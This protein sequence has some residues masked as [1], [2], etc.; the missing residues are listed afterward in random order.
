[1]E[2]L[3]QKTL[4]WKLYFIKILQFSKISEVSTNLKDNIQISET[5]R[6]T[7]DM[8][9]DKTTE[10]AGF[11]KNDESFTDGYDTMLSRI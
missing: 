4:Q 11:N 1:M 3:I 2:I 5:D 9:L 6:N 10:M 8:R 7:D